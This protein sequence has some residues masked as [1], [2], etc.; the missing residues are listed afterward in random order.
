VKVLVVDPEQET[1]DR[2]EAELQPGVTV[3]KARSGGEGLELARR[4]RPDLVLLDL[5]ENGTGSA[6]G[7]EVAAALRAEPRTS[8]IPIL[9]MTGDHELSASDRERLKGQVD[10]TLADGEEGTRHLLRTLRQLHR[11]SGANGS[12]ANHRVSSQARG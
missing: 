1:L 8:H 4:H 3:L 5:L 12:R 2:L 11:G 7:F 9:G 10:A 6:T